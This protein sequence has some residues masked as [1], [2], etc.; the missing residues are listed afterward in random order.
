MFQTE[1]TIFFQSLSSDFLTAIFKLFSYIG[2]GFFI[3]PLLIAITFGVHFR[4]GTILIHLAFWN[5]VLTDYLKDVFALPRPFNVDAAV[6]L[7]GES[8]PNPT[9][10]KGMGA[11]SFFGFLPG[12]VIDYFRDQGVWLD[13]VKS[14]GLPSG[15]TSSAA[16]LWGAIFL[17]FKK[18]N[19]FYQRLQGIH[20]NTWVRVISITFI[21]FIPL[22][23]LYLA[24]HFL[25]DILAGFLLG[26]FVL[27]LFYRFVFLNE[28]LKEWL[29]EKTGILKLSLKS[30]AF[31]VY[32]LLFPFLLLL[33][34]QINPLAAPT[35]LG[36][37]C[38]FFLLWLRGLPEEGGT[39]L[40]RLGRIG[41]AI[42]F[43]FGMNL[44]LKGSTGLL[45]S[46]EPAIITF[47]RQALTV[48]LLIW[49]A[50]EINI[51]LGLYRRIVP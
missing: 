33:S 19:F 18:S 17:F 37:N 15:H 44:V 27:M 6:Q 31:L 50:A 51:K 48:F 23:R 26:F 30:I 35:L 42:L 29:F 38:G 39:F 13:G 11:K 7:P 24:Y 47:T 22:S 16:A 8:F 41:V 20:I 40:Q 43:Y 46:R 12:Q 4:L 25:A 3:I 14:F 28:K 1:I 34:P 9:P 49:G 45:F 10:F 5:G 32:I 2:S 36:M 21:V